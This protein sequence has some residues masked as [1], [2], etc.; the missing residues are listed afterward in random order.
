MVQIQSYKLVHLSN[1]EITGYCGRVARY[2]KEGLT[3]EEVEKALP[4]LNSLD[5]LN[6]ALSNDA[7]RFTIILHRADHSA[8]QGWK[9]MSYL[10][11]VGKMHYDPEV[12]KAAKQVEDIFNSFE[13]PTR[14]TYVK[15]YAVMIRLIAALKEL[16]DVVLQ[17]VGI[18]G[19]LEELEDRVN[20]FLALESEKVSKKSESETGTIQK[21]RK[22]LVEAYREMITHL[23]A[24]LVLHSTPAFEAF[25]AKLN[26]LIDQQRAAAKAKA[27]RAKEK[28]KGKAKTAKENEAAPKQD[29]AKGSDAAKADTPADAS[30]AED[31]KGDAA[32]TSE[33]KD[34]A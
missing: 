32:G 10:I 30:A 34:P 20:E 2:I 4:F 11:K 26:E 33:N 19:W 14:M 3:P 15:G 12:R 7:K 21:A 8:D 31:L 5:T 25:A 1:D 13:N 17:K 23:N 16:P 9:A 24:V 22:A 27:T 6:Q 29:A 18:D 28:D